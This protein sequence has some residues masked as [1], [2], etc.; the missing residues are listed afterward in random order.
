MHIVF[1]RE[2]RIINALMIHSSFIE[3]IGFLNG[4][5]GLALYFF[6]LGY[7]KNDE[8]F[9]HFAEG[10]LDEVIVSLHVDLPVDFE[11]GITGIGWGIEYLI[12]NGF[13]EGNADEILEEIDAKVK[14]VFIHEECTMNEIIS[15]G[16]YLM[17]RISDRSNKDD[18]IIVLD[19]KYHIIL[20]IDEVEKQIA[21]GR[22]EALLYNF[23]VELR[24]LNVFNYKIDKL[25]S[26]IDRNTCCYLLPYIPRLTLFGVEQ[27]MN[28][29][30][31][32]SKYAGFD[33]RHVSV[34]ERWGIKKGIA[35]FGLQK[36]YIEN[37][38]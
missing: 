6:C 4:K 33:M 8:I 10:L 38:L 22:R 23:L 14:H 34:S 9:T 30:D 19:M 15:I 16:Y 20:L 21:N 29:K 26:M 17:S 25:L 18:N 2:Q 28:S 24:K 11:N 37:G 13:I 3:D 36:L 31:V 1:N 35:G 27:T 7:F 32:K 5:M 12:K